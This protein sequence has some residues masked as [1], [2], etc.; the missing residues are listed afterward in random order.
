M[1][2]LARLIVASEV[3]MLKVVIFS[4]FLWQVAVPVS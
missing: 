4:L 2:I 3:K 1:T